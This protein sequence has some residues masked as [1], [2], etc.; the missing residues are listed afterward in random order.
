MNH[1]L[2]LYVLGRRFQIEELRNTVMDLVRRYYHTE[3]MTAPAFR[4][5]YIY[6]NTDAPCPMREFLVRTAAYRALSETEKGLTDS[7]KGAIRGG[8]DLAIDFVG[9]LLEEVKSERVDARKGDNCRWHEHEVTPRCSISGGF[10][11]YEN[12]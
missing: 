11:A 4:L 7:V 6:T 12:P 1:Y 8:G 5:E 2:C 9:A 3:Q 10:E